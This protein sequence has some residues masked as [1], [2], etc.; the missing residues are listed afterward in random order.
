[1]KTKN[2]IFVAVD[3][4]GSKLSV[5][6]ASKNSEGLLQII[7]V[8]SIALPHESIHYGVIKKPSVVATNLIALLENLQKGIQQKEKNTCEISSFY[9]GIDG[10]TLRTESRSL[11]K[12]FQKKTSLNKILLEEIVRQIKQKLSDD[13]IF[14]EENYPSENTTSGVFVYEIFPQS[15]VVD[16]ILCSNPLDKICTLLQMKFLMARCGLEL[17]AGYNAVEKEFG[18]T[19]IKIKKSLAGISLG[20]AFLTEEE[21][22]NGAVLIDFGAQ[23]TTFVAYKNGILNYLGCVPLGGDAITKDLSE[24]VGADIREAEKIKCEFG[25]VCYE[26][27]E[28]VYAGDTHVSYRKM[29]SIIKTRQLEIIDFVE[30]HLEKVGFAD[31]LKQI[32]VITGGASQMKNLEALLVNEKMWRVRKLDLSAYAKS[33]ISHLQPENA[34]LLS[35]LINAKDACCSINKKKEEK[36][37]KGKGNGI[38]IFD[39]LNR[40]FSDPE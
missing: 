40:M 7:D 32:V 38:G 18:K 34:L 25:T 36:K 4:G 24:L 15:Y 2:D 10:N 1:M 8:E 37:D 21:K 16:D 27:S 20:E 31:L 23:R 11:R 12:Q 6:A 26:S 28:N 30:Q 29:L 3:L 13:G 9:L 19:K 14:S 35:L 33:D 39:T 22:N 17:F 5:M